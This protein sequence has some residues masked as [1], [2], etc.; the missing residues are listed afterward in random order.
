[1]YSR[2]DDIQII[3]Q[4]CLKNNRRAQEELYKRY[5]PAMMALCLRYLRDR[6]DALEVLNDALLKVFKQMGRFDPVKA[7]LYTWMRTI[8]IN[9]ALDA[10]RKQKAL[11]DREMMPEEEEEPGVDNQAIAKLNGDELL[12]VIR[13]LPVTTR[14]VFNLYVI[15]GYAHKEIAALLSI[16]EGTSRWHLNDA[17]R[18]LKMILNLMEPKT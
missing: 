2:E 16:S 12:G 8:V 13:Q 9:T 5:Y 10:L 11:R 7:A 4:G 6:Q 15:D 18:Q 1:M 17:R 14:T 3:I